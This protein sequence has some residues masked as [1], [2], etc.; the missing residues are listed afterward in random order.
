MPRW[1]IL[2]RRF[3]ERVEAVE[4]GLVELHAEREECAAAGVVLGAE[5][6]VAEAGVAQA[7]GSDKAD[8]ERAIAQ[9]RNQSSVLSMPVSA[10]PKPLISWLKK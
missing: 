9:S 10:T 3:A 1:R 4:E 6:A 2:L 8:I 7:R 5:V